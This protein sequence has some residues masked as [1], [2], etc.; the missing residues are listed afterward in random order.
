MARV[1]RPKEDSLTLRLGDE[2]YKVS[3]FLFASYSQKVRSPDLLRT[4]EYT[5]QEQFDPSTF[6]QFCNACQG[7]PYLLHEG[8][9]EEMLRIAEYFDCQSVKEACQARQPKDLINFL[10]GSADETCL[11][12]LEEYLKK[13]QA[14]KLSNEQ[15]VQVLAKAKE[16]GKISDQGV[17]EFVVRY[18]KCHRGNARVGEALAHVDLQNI[19]IQELSECIELEQYPKTVDGKMFFELL[20]KFNGSGGSSLTEL[21]LSERATAQTGNG[22]VDIWLFTVWRARGKDVR[23]IVEIT[24]A[25]PNWSQHLYQ[26]LGAE[27]K[28]AEQGGDCIK[29]QF[30]EPMHITRIELHFHKYWPKCYQL[31]CLDE[32]GVKSDLEKKDY[33]PPGQPCSFDDKSGK[34][35][36]ELVYI[37][38]ITQDVYGDEQKN[39][40]ALRAFDV[41]VRIPEC[42]L[43]KHGI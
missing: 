13:P 31:E 28:K 29:F 1:T 34:S 6:Q 39:T 36:R 24:T 5:V 10:N 11:D 21:K 40:I 17:I 9:V 22:E 43:L 41:K 38:T 12:N 14:M 30:K 27:Q 4:T 19:S 2:E 15:V 23:D 7:Y 16:K 18:A 8:N 35:I 33:H 37:Q 20:R 42:W 32:K 3:K 25:D 26:V